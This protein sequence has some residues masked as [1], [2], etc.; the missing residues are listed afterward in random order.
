LID[1]ANGRI[2]T[3]NQRTVDDAYPHHITYSWCPA[4]RHDRIV[5]LLGELGEFTVE[6]FQEMQ[7]DVH[8]RQAEKL[9]PAVLQRSFTN[10]LAAEAVKIL[11]AWDY[12]LTPDS[13]P[14]VVFQAFYQ[15]FI[16]V[17]T[18]D[19]LGNTLP[20]YLSIIPIFHSVAEIYLDPDR[21]RSTELLAGKDL[22]QVCEQSL[23]RAMRFLEEAFGVDRARWSW[24]ALH[25]YHYE[26]PGARGVLPSWLLNRGPYPAGGSAFTVNMANYN[27]ARSGGPR[28]QYTVTTS[29]SL[30]LVTSLADVDRTFI[31]GPMGQSGRPGCPHYADMIEP[32]IH[33]RGVPLPLSREGAEQIA[34]RRTTLS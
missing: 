24:G 15:A 33:G 23:V 25:R 13:R 5:E 1:P 32:W 4:Y 26:H 27:L 22:G 2:V 3:A 18:E 10:P 29:P 30:R 7:R 31:M 17:L 19:L 6:A 12:R 14:G 34:V 11:E 8:S 16:E 20:I 21:A 28:R 9:L